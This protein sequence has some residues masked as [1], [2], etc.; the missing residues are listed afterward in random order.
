[1]S[2]SSLYKNTS[3]LSRTSRT[4]EW[5]VH[6]IKIIVLASSFTIWKSINREPLL[7]SDLFSRL[8]KTKTD[9]KA[10]C[11]RLKAYKVR[12]DTRAK[13]IEVKVTHN[14]NHWCINIQVV[15]RT[16]PEEINFSI[17]PTVSTVVIWRLERRIWALRP[18]RLML[19]LCIPSTIGVIELVTDHTKL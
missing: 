17:L 19:S 16:V 15:A 12:S 8:K 13:I 7:R 6:Q 14:F 10:T 4:S 9:T 5:K 1:M 3:S 2:I 11:E 18:V